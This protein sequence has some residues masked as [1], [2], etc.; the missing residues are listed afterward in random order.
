MKTLRAAILLAWAALVVT[1]RRLLRGPLHPLYRWRVEV[2]IRF[3]RRGILSGLRNGL[4]RERAR[5]P[6]TRVPRRCARDVIVERDGQLAGRPVEITTFAGWTEA[7]PV[8]LYLHGGG[9]VACSPKTHRDLTARLAAVSRARVVALDYRLAPEHPFPAGLDD[10]VAACHE[11]RAEPWGRTEAF[12]I[13]GDSAG[14]GLALATMVRLR[15]EG[16]A[17]PA[18]GALLSPWVDLAATGESIRRNAPY[19]FVTPEAL[20]HYKSRYLDHGDPRDPLA[21]PLYAELG[22]LPPLLI[23]TGSTEV[24]HSEALELA[25]RAEGAGVAVTLQ[26]YEGVCHA[27]QTMAALLPEAR[28]AI[29]EVGSFVRRSCGLGSTE[30]VEQRAGRSDSVRGQMRTSTR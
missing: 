10:A 4:D 19:C 17:L 16:A 9:Y 8:V 30:R 26:I 23:Q 18:G 21:S 20:E 15:D 5:L 6:V 3:L 14:G 24:L 7:D 28:E 12:V 1:I 29:A 2:L 11:L 27:F 13:A 25:R 22:G